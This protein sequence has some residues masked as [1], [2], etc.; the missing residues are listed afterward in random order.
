MPVCKQAEKLCKISIKF[1]KK[2]CIRKPICQVYAKRFICMKFTNAESYM[3]NFIMLAGK[4]VAYIRPTKTL[5]NLTNAHVQNVAKLSLR[6]QN[7]SAYANPL[8]K[9]QPNAVFAD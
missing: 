1:A 2:S 9:F 8:T 3:R 7:K 4:L 5:A 6:L